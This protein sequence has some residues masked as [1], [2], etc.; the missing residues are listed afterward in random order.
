MTEDIFERLDRK[1]AASKA[2]QAAAAVKTPRDCGCPGSK[3]LYVEMTAAHQASIR[4]HCL[5][6]QSGRDREENGFPKSTESKP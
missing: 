1:I 6:R 4:C 3:C 5:N 2:R